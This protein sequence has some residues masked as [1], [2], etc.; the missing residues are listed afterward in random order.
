MVAG[1]G[2]QRPVVERP[3]R[4]GEEVLS[5][6]TEAEMDWREIQ[7]GDGQGFLPCP[8]F[9][10]L[11]SVSLVFYLVLLY[12]ACFLPVSFGTCFLAN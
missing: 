10:E 4:R 1:W 6:K 7:E 9:Q 11:W 2:S 3:V 5:Q 8:T 12:S